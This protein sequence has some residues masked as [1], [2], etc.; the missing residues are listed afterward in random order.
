VNVVQP[1]AVAVSA[2]LLDNELL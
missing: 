2:F 1:L